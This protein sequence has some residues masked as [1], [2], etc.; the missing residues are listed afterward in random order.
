MTNSNKAYKNTKKHKKQFLSFNWFW[1]W[2]IQKIFERYTE[3]NRS[4]NYSNVNKVI[5]SYIESQYS[6]LHIS[7]QLTDRT[8]FDWEENVKKSLEKI[9]FK[10]E[11]YKTNKYFADLTLLIKLYFLFQEEAN[12]IPT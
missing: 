4:N 8:G 9:G 3:F 6:K 10:V 11:W 2:N 7:S 12:I 1:I 5:Y